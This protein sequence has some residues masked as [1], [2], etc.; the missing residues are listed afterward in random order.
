MK[1]SLII[2]TKNEEKNLK[3]VLPDI[4][5]IIE[6]ILIIDGGS[7][8]NTINEAKKLNKNCRI[9]I[10]KE[11]G[12]G[13][14]IRKSI[15]LASGEYLLFIDADGSMAP[16]EL[17]SICSKLEEGY[18]FV[19]G[20]RMLKG[21]GTEDMTLLRKIGNLMFVFLVRL[22]FK[23]KITDLCYGLF[24]IRKELLQQF[25][26]KSNGFEIETEITLKAI[27]RHVKMVE[28]PSFERKRVYGK[29]N[30][31]TVVDGWKILITILKEFFGRE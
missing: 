2:P 11:K 30:L 6:E 28:I 4:P 14:A 31:N 9:Y 12:K 17:K 13:I 5:E 16:N 20:S 23:V 3:Y 21:G 15:K 24:G 22:L 19:K 26:L 10:E 1:Y 8:D 29:T 18:D 27:K 7:K 25:N